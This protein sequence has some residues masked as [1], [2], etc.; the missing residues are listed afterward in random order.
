MRYLGNGIGHQATNHLHGTASS[1]ICDPDPEEVGDD[2]D[3][4]KPEESGEDSD[5]M[6]SDEDD[7]YGYNHNK[8]MEMDE[9][10]SDKVDGIDEDDDWESMYMD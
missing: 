3:S 10:E 8:L 4:D 2:S 6:P 9:Q 1:Q 5:L 7:D